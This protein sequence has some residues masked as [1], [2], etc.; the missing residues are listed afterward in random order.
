MDQSSLEYKV[1]GRLKFFNEGQGYGFIL[2]D[3][4]Q[5]DLFFHYD[6]MKKTNL[7]KQFLKDAKNRFIVRFQF[8]VMAYYGKYS[9]SKKAV[10]I[11]L[12]KIEPII[13]DS[14]VTLQS[15]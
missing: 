12:L 11:E 10:D 7:S 14:S 3:I 9:L 4:D 8:K 13:G 6:D 15:Q 5:K 1:T 2:S